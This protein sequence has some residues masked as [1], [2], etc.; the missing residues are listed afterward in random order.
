MQR[1]LPP[2]SMIVGRKADEEEF[3]S[4]RLYLPVEQHD[5]FEASPGSQK[6]Y[7]MKETSRFIKRA[8]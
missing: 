4:L 5:P 6:V 1:K 7:G 2:R 3:F 8:K